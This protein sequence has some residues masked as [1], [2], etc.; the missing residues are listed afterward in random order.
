MKNETDAEQA[1]ADSIWGDGSWDDGALGI[2]TETNDG[3][4]LLIRANFADGSAA[5]KWNDME[6]LGI[7]SDWLGDPDLSMRITSA[8]LAEHSWQPVSTGNKYFAA[9]QLGTEWQKYARPKKKENEVEK[10]KKG[11]TMTDPVMER[12][13][14]KFVTYM[15]YDALNGM[16][17]D[18]RLKAQGVRDRI[19]NTLM[20]NLTTAEL[21]EEIRD[22]ESYVVDWKNKL[23]GFDILADDWEDYARHLAS[24]KKEERKSN[25][26]G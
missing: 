11:Q 9:K 16:L 18:L 21:A 12:K 14:K 25:E 7:H 13:I 26:E 22:I 6:E 20:K 17:D 23:D 4:L 3:G 2:D 8:L 15:Q 24:K 19:G 10:K 1:E 5:V